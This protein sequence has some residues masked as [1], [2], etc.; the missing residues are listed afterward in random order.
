MVFNYIFILLAFYPWASFA[1]EVSSLEEILRIAYLKNSSIKAGRFNYDAEKWL[2]ISKATPDNPMIG[3]STLDR[4]IQTRYAT[5]TQKVRFPTKYVLQAKAQKSRANS[6]KTKLESNKL[7]VRQE[8]ISL[9]YSIY[10]TQKIIHLA[11]ANKRAVKDFARV[12]EK[13]YAAGRS[14]QGDSMKAHLELTRIEL[15]LIGLKQEEDALQERLKAVVNV[16]DFKKVHLLNLKIK[17]PQ[18]RPNPI[19]ESQRELALMLK[20]TSPKVKTELHLLKEAEFKS[21]LSKWE[22]APDFQFQYQQAIA[23][24]PKDSKI[25]SMA[26]TIPLWFW[27]KS[28]EAQ[29]ASSKRM[30]Q[31]SRVEETLQRLVAKLRGLKGKVETG[32]KTLNIY[33]TSLIPQAQG[34]YHSTHGAYRANK[35]SFLDLLDSERSLYQVKTGFYKSLRQYVGYLTE[36]ETQ[37]GFNVSNLDLNREVQK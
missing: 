35:T 20:S 17:T 31:E 14:P 18:F 25:Y 12:A 32:V 6:Y 36:L 3:V 16:Q 4:N 24:A 28:S 2:I 30:A 22:Y 15:D 5:I 33:E 34:A 19:L 10:S 27:K 23:G 11:Q 37:L 7:R 9:Y 8:V 13:K 1:K 29:V 21:S 26:M